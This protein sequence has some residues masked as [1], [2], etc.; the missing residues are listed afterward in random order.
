MRVEAI[1]RYDGPALAN[2]QMDINE[3]APALLALGDLIRDTNRI[4]N[5]G[6]TSVRVLVNADTEQQCFQLGFNVV[7]S[8]SDQIMNLIGQDGVKDAKEILEWLGIIAGV[9]G[10]VTA[11]VFGVLKFLAWTKKQGVTYHIEAKEGSII[12][13]ADNGASINVP[14]PVHKLVQAPEIIKNA[15]KVIEPVDTEGISKL[16]FEQKGRITH[17]ISDVEAKDILNLQSS[18]I[19]EDVQETEHVSEIRT[20]VRIKRAIYEGAGKWTIIYQTPVEAKIS[21]DKFVKKFQSGEI[22]APPRSILD[23]DLIVSVPIDAEGI[24]IG[25]PSYEVTKVHSVRL[26]PEQPSLI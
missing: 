4:L 10:G 3:L 18:W 11:S 13:L 25:K 16:E 1:I 9:G 5:G 14:P 7:Q 24:S 2:H 15:K 12:Y 17:E 21:D 23:V 26:Q 19:I 20:S 6:D 22:K 8:I